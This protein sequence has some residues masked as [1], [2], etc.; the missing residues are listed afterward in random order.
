[1][2]DENT[3]V[4]NWMRILLLLLSGA[5]FFPQLGRLYSRGDSSGISRYYMLC[6]LISATEQLTLALA[7]LVNTGD[8]GGSDFFLH[9]PLTLGDRL[10]IAQLAVVWA[11]SLVVF[12]LCLY[13]PSTHRDASNSQ[14]TAIYTS[15]LLLSLL[16]ALALLWTP[17]ADREDRRRLPA[18]FHGLHSLW[19]SPLVT[20]LGLAAAFFQLREMREPHGSSPGRSALSLVGLAAQAVTFAVVAVSWALRVVFP[21]SDIPA[22]ARLGLGFFGSWYQL[23][24]WAAV[25]NGVFALVQGVVWCAAMRRIGGVGSGEGEREPLIR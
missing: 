21:W 8:D 15:F 11:L 24:G 12:L 4:P 13:Y 7:L 9:N 18:L 10:N 3:M 17:P 6:N 23:V 1:M 2:S 25:D 20:L 14:A 16:P 5:S 22:D 19:L